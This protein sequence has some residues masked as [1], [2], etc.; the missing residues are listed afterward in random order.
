MYFHQTGAVFPCCFA[1]RR[2]PIGDVRRDQVSEIWNSPRYRKLRLRM[3]AG[4]RSATCTRC[5]ELEQAGATSHRLRMNEKFARHLP[6]AKT[7]APDG[8]VAALNMPYVDIRFSNVCNFRCRTCGHGSS[9]SWYAD[10]KALWPHLEIAP[11]LR[12][13]DDPE[14]LWSQVRDLV[15]TAEEIYFGGGEPLVM[16]E[17]Y[18]VLDLL[19]ERGRTDVRLSYNSN[20]SS[21][22]YR[23]RSVLDLWRR[24]PHVRV[25]A[26]LDA[27]GPRAEILRA[28]TRWPDILDNLRRI[29]AHCPHV[30]LACSTTVSA[31]N[32]LALPDLHR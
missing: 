9:S 10:A 32:A 15:A 23:G 13:H 12:A 2:L 28:G 24:F 16:E 19:L 14:H 31:M 8:R 5:Y 21:V 7:T 30:E 4:Q 22:D 17:H 1:D 26:S 25:D 11:I 3:L 27:S 6:L 18:R 20:L 29:R